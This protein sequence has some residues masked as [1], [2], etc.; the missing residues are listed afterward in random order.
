VAIIASILV[1]GGFSPAIG[2]L[3]GGEL[4]GE[5]ARKGDTG[6][7]LLSGMGNN[8]GF[9]EKANGLKSTDA[10]LCAEAAIVTRGGVVKLGV[11]KSSVVLG[12]R[13][14]TASGERGVT[15]ISPSNPRPGGENSTGTLPKFRKRE[16][17]EKGLLRNEEEK[18]EFL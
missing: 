16:T 10:S 17:S 13:Q 14:G 15:R 11:G 1:I 4:G 6:D 8:R 3:C 7:E 2:I 18:M 12:L 5:G 9:R